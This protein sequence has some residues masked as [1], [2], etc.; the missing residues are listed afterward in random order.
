MFELYYFKK[1]VLLTNENKEMSI[2][3][4][5]KC[6]NGYFANFKNYSHISSSCI[7]GIVVGDEQVI[8]Q[9]IVCNKSNGYDFKL[10][11]DIDLS[12]NITC[13]LLDTDTYRPVAWGGNG[14][15]IASRSRILEYISSFSDG[16]KKGNVNHYSD[17]NMS[18]DFGSVQEIDPEKK[19]KE[20]ETNSK[21]IKTHNSYIDKTDIQD[22]PDNQTVEEKVL[23]RNAVV[24]GMRDVD[25]TQDKEVKL[26]EVDDENIEEQIDEMVD[27]IYGD[28]FYEMI[29][30]QLD[31]LFAKFPADEVLERLIPNS[32]W[33]RV[34]YDHSTNGYVLGL[35]YEMETLKYVSYGV[36][37]KFGDTLPPTMDRYNQWVPAD[38]SD[39]EGDGYYIMFQDALTGKTIKI[40]DRM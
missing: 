13:M 27:N 18:N 8:K 33:V 7:L 34:K 11:K 15:K 22:V 1:T 2:L 17:K 24:Y 30:E 16:A 9:N 23:D 21:T 36:P 40:D 26:F 28:H 20:T 12:K 10:S 4:L 37:A 39:P 35:I 25:E 14:D 6:Y 29:K 3:E 38:V 31:D 32:K 5:R 19:L